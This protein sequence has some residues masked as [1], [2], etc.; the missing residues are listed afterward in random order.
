MNKLCLVL[1]C[2]PQWTGSS[3]DSSGI[4]GRLITYE[5]LRVLLFIHLP[6]FGSLLLTSCLKFNGRCWEHGD[7]SIAHLPFP[8]GM[9]LVLMGLTV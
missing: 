4:E 5:K 8:K 3:G 9:V 1:N 7:Y 6:D 2:E